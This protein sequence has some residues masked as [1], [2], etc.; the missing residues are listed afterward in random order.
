M[1][2]KLRKR[3][4]PPMVVA[5]LALFVAL[6]G[7]TWAGTGG[8][9][10]LGHSN[11]ANKTTALSSPADGPALR[12]SNTGS[13][14]GLVA[15]AGSG[16]GVQGSGDTAGG[17]FDGRSSG[18]GVQGFTE[19]LNRSGVYGRHTGRAA[20]FGVFASTSNGTGV[21]G[22]GTV[23]GGSFSGT[24]TGDGVQGA[25]TAA[26]KSG[27]WAHHDG[28]NS[29]FG[30]FAQSSTGPAIGMLGN[31]NSPPITLDGSPFPAATAGFKD[32]AVGL[33]DGS[34]VT[35]ATLDDIAPGTYV[36]LA[37]LWAQ[38]GSADEVDCRL[39]AGAD[40]D[41]QIAQGDLVAAPLTMLVYH[42]FASTGS[43]LLRCESFG[44]FST[45]H[46]TKIAAIQVSG[47]TNTPLP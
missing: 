25:A 2:G 21:A 9:F 14:D 4:S 16:R 1:H 26:G 12:T 8:N 13:G 23:A 44:G 39:Q 42:T 22:Y 10:I 24:G 5:L 19:G 41:D 43:A 47:G 7:T 31:G 27:V 11:D 30:L 36:L 20:G 35:V 28:G 45:A 40:R 15:S 37:K 29:G 38:M 3:F 46:D 18:D 33:P 6:A 34:F 32:D 17:S